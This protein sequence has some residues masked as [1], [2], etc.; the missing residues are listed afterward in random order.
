MGHTLWLEDLLGE[1]PHAGG[2]KSTS[3]YPWKRAGEMNK[4][5][6]LE[7]LGADATH[8][9]AEASLG[10]IATTQ[11]TETT[12]GGEALLPLVLKA[13]GLFPGKGLRSELDILFFVL[14]LGIGV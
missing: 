2:T 12:I 4:G 6:A 5:G 10:T 13:G 1:K 3:L 9:E 14:R 7:G 11:C 8:P